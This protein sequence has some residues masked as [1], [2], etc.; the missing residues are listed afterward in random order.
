MVSY[1]IDAVFVGRAQPFGPNGEPSAI[2]KSPVSGPVRLER[3]GLEGDEHVYHLHGGRDK[4]LFQHAEEHYRMWAE[5]FPDFD[6]GRPVFGENILTEGM[7]ESTVCVGDRYAIGSEV[8]VEVSQPRQPC[9][10][11]GYNAGHTELPRLMQELGATGWYYRV[12]TPGAIRA[13]DTL[14][15]LE[16]PLPEWTLSRVVSGFYGTPMDE[17]LLRSLM[18]LELLGIEWRA[19]ARNRL[20]SGQVEAWD[21]RLYGP[22]EPEP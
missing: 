4:A 21:E 20:E 19:A 22:L 6:P 18:E 8:V 17:G 13:G 5:R 10:K 16:R 14:K 2:R 1:T 7:T 12:I 11:I 15:L 3:L 9:W